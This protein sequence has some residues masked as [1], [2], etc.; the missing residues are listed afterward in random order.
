MHVIAALDAERQAVAERG[1]EVPRPRTQ[2]DDDV[3]ALQRAA[4]GGDGPARAGSLQRTRVAVDEP[5]AALD[6]QIGVGAGQPFRVGRRQRIAEVHA[7][8]GDVAQVR[9]EREEL[10]A[11][12]RRADDAERFRLLDVLEREVLPTRSA[13]HLDPAAFA[14]QRARARRLGEGAMLGDAAQHQP[15]RRHPDGKSRLL[16]RGEKIAPHPRR[17]RGQGGVPNLH[18]RIEVE[19]GDGDLGGGARKH[20]G[21]ERLA[22]HDAGV[23]EARPAPCGPEPIDERHGAAARLRMQRRADAD[24]SRSQD[25]DI[26]FRRGHAAILLS[27]GLGAPLCPARGRPGNGP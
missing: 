24:D 16:R 23:A 20:V 18:P 4:L 10:I 15:A 1:R 9:L 13:E 8:L 19:R 17:D 12:Q 21:E 5:A 26:G 3:R 6:E 7:A 11:G 25:D 27:C 2:R 22:L 14:Q